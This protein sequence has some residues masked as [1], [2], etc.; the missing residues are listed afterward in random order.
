[1][2]HESRQA[3]IAVIGIDGAGKTTQ[4]TRLTQWLQELGHPASYRLAAGGR[5][6]VSN[7]ARHLGRAD[8][9]TL[10]GPKLAIRTETW[11]RH[12]NLALTYRAS[13]LIADRYD[14]CQFARARLVYPDLEPWVRRR[15]APHPRPDLMLY[16]ALPAEVAALRVKRRGIDDEPVHQL[17]ALD[18][19]YRSLPE[20]VDYTILDANRH[21]DVV[22][23][24][25][26][27]QVR[28]AL[29][30]LFGDKA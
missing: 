24:D 15:L 1:M 4:A 26:Q 2:A 19:A 20:S 18:A 29:P 16:L 5:R 28:S 27:E 21:P 12:V 11:L 7:A 10:L 22:T 6:V 14:V 17:V 23:S 25:I 9:V 8:S 13:I 3:T 30:S